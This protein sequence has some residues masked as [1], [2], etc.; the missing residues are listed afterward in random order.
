MK[1]IPR[2]GALIVVITI[3]I[4]LLIVKT[5]IVETQSLVVVK[6]IMNPFSKDCGI[7]A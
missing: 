7:G 3:V 1:K 5:E 4:T 2:L 6:D